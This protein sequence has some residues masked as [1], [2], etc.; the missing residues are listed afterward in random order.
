MI[1]IIVDNSRSEIRPHINF[2]NKI[3]PVSGDRR[4]SDM[5][6]PCLD[7]SEAC[8]EGAIEEVE[9]LIRAG[10][11]VNKKEFYGWTP[12]HRAVISGHTDIVKL[13][14]EHGAKLSEPPPLIR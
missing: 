1:N 2:N 12:I 8:E 6:E 10:V 11:D 9:R 7:I 13:L 4:S 5:D 14:L 3:Y